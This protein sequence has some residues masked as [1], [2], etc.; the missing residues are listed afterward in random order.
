MPDFC[1]WHFRCFFGR[2]HKTSIYVGSIALLFAAIMAKLRSTMDKVV[3]LGYQDENGFHVG[4]EPA[5]ERKTWPST[6]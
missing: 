6:R 5:P 4:E 3:P 1:A 2:M